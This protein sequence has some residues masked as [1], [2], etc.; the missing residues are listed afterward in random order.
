MDQRGD[1]TTVSVV[2]KVPID[3][4]PSSVDFGHAEGI[5]TAVGQAPDRIGG[6]GPSKRAVVTDHRPV[7]IGDVIVT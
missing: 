5:G 1:A 2:V 3:R 4:N 6:V 7:R